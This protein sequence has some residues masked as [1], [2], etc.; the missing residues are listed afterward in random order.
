MVAPQILSHHGEHSTVG[1]ASKIEREA[2]HIDLSG[3]RRF[4]IG[5]QAQGSQDLFTAPFSTKEFLANC[6]RLAGGADIL[7]PLVAGPLV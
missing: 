1:T 4:L 7:A 5:R 2:L 6:Q 3:Q